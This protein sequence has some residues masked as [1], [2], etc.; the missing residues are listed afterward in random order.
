MP[1]NDSLFGKK[2]FF[3][4]PPEVIKE[5][6][7][8]LIESEYEIYT[9]KDQAKL[10]RYLRRNPD[11]LVFVNIDEGDDESIWRSW[12]RS[13]KDNEASAATRFGVITMMSD[14][15]KKQTYLM[16]IGIECGFIVVKIGV[17]KTTEIL[18]RMLEANEAKGRRKY[19]RTICPE[20][21]ADF[22][23]KTS[24]GL[25]RGSLKDLSSAGMATG[26][27]DSFAPG[28]G[29]RLKDLQ[30]NLKGARVIVSGV[31]IGGRDD[32]LKGPTRVVM[33]E[34]GSLNDDKRSKLRSFVRKLLQSQMEQELSQ[35]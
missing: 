2:V 26:F 35:A 13:V 19:V 32:D 17:A 1:S 20:D 8:V 30:L 25:I 29:T 12:I 34:P 14:D 3:L 4:N 27:V 23:C 18:L 33:F 22:T 7:P 9:T 21:A 11:C 10:G 5:V 15:A 6:L 28:T 24:A 31:V 16:D